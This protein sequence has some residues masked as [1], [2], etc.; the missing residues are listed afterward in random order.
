MHARCRNAYVWLPSFGCRTDLFCA[1]H[2]P[3]RFSRAAPDAETRTTLD[4]TQAHDEEKR[5]FESQLRALFEGTRGVDQEPIRAS[6]ADLDEETARAWNEKWDAEKARTPDADPDPRD[7][8]DPSA[9]ERDWIVRN[10]ALNRRVWLPKMYGLRTRNPYREL[11][12]VRWARFAGDRGSNLE[13]ALGMTV[14]GLQSLSGTRFHYGEPARRSC[15]THAC[16]HA[17][18]R[19]R[20][21]CRNTHALPVRSRGHRWARAS[22]PDARGDRDARAARLRGARDRRIV[23]PVLPPRQLQ[24]EQGRADDVLVRVLARRGRAAACV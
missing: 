2:S 17:P 1:R 21:V 19:R 4:D 22:P 10:R 15:S 14:E 20:R 11:V 13:R 8:H 18:A 3:R 6:Q 23:H 12:A 9:V 24:R 7:A 16:V 5:A